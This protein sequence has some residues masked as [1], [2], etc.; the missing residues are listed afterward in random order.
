MASIFGQT[1]QN[2]GVIICYDDNRCLEYL[3]EY[4]IHPQMSIYKAPEVCKKEPFFYNLYCNFLLEKVTDGWI[5]FIDDD[6][7][8]TEKS[9]LMQ[10]SQTIMSTDDFLLWKVRIGT[11]VVFPQRLDEIEYKSVSG[12]GFCVHSLHKDKATWVATQGSDFKYISE[13]LRN[14]PTF[15]RKFIPRILAGTT[16]RSIGNRGIT[17]GTPMTEALRLLNVRQVYISS[18]LARFAK[19]FR[20]GH[21]LRAYD[22]PTQPAVFFGVYND[23]DR[24]ALLHHKAETVIAPG[25]ID[26]LNVPQVP[27]LVGDRAT[28]ILSVSR[29]MQSRLRNM[30][31]H[32]LRVELNMADNKTFKPTPIAE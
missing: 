10:M 2:F 16:H 18:S 17:D 22:D 28:W 21:N 23:L 9:S 14:Y 7:Q 24:K 20:Y 11:H 13:L 12:E 32:T 5:V 26:I 29:D 4:K 19:E 8:F 1:Y 3:H 25:G 15:R 31:I 30:N 27:Q 6:D